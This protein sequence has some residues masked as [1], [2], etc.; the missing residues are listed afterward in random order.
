MALSVAVSTCR[1]PDGLTRLLA[2]LMEADG[3]DFAWELIV[4]AN[5]PD[6]AARTRTESWPRGFPA[7]LRVVHE[8]RLGLSRA[9]NRAV[10]VARYPLV[11][12][13][14][15]DVT[16]GPGWLSAYERAFAD[17]KVGLAAGPVAPAWRA[18]PPS[19]IDAR[20]LAD[21]SC[22][23]LGEDPRRAR[24]GEV[25]GANFA[26][27]RELLRGLGGFREDLGRRGGRLLSGEEFDLA[28]RAAAAGHGL[29]YVPEARVWHDIDPARL[30][31][32]WHL[33]RSYWGGRTAVRL[34]GSAPSESDAAGGRARR[35]AA[36]RRAGATLFDEARHAAW[37]A[38]VMVEHL[39]GGARPGGDRCPPG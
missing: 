22:L 31:R 27:R 9:R 38:G 17:A 39:L 32:A 6:A 34:A 25:V 26:A 2:S 10:G 28:R 37:R 12:F 23:D 24:P 36:R 30:R 13:L 18:E 16:V 14:D 35:I 15:D 19:W 20:A 33:R 11:A 29:L 4:V 8:P 3:C 5:G 1:R 21:L 7:P